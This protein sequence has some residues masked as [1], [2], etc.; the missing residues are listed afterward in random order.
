MTKHKKF[1]FKVEIKGI[2]KDNA[3]D[4][5]QKEFSKIQDEIQNLID[6]W[7]VPD[8]NWSINTISGEDKDIN[9]K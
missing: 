1:E 4:T 8:N 7:G 9:K 3:L 5:I 6:K 2:I